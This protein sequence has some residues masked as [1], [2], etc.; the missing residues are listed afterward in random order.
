M[1]GVIS[2]KTR[3]LLLKQADLTLSKDMDICHADEAALTQVK[4]MSTK[5]AA[6]SEGAEN[7]DLKALKAKRSFQPSKQQSQCGNCGGRHLAR[8]KC[9]AAGSQCY[10]CGLQNHFAWVC[11]SGTQ[12]SRQRVHEIH[13]DQEASSEKELVVAAVENE[14]SRKDWSTTVTINAHH[15]TFKIDTG[16]QCNVMSNNTYKRVS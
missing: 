3:S 7:L 9:P 13:E 5:H 14:P 1:C 4:S 12:P 16:A 6:S 8:K 2:D 11:R 15:I 10:K